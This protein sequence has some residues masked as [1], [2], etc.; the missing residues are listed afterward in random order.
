L[1]LG[2]SVLSPIH[3]LTYYVSGLV[4]QSVPDSLWYTVRDSVW[5][6]ELVRGTIVGKIENVSNED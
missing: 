6:A 3:R 5:S 4:W 1:N 2:I